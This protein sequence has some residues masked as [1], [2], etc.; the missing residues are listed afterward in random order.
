MIA[1]LTGTIVKK[2]DNTLILDV[3]GVGYRVH[4]GKEIGAALGRIGEKAK[5]WTH[6]SVRETSLDLFGFLDE[7]DLVF[8]E[9]L[10][11]ISGIGPKSALAIL[12]VAPVPTLTAAI[13]EGDSSYLTKVSG[14][15]K[16][17]AEKIILEL[18]DKLDVISGDTSGARTQEEVDAI[19]ALQALGYSTKEAREALKQVPKEVAGTNARL[20]EALRLLGK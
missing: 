8:F 13:L 12:N 15:G 17:N 9:K 18:K 10:I 16:K 6:L 4:I 11:L 5:L 1:Q 3:S 19:D 7:R 14:I 20:K 2:Q